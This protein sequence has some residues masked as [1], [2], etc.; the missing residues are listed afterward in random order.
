MALRHRRDLDHEMEAIAALPGVRRELMV[1]GKLSVHEEF[2]DEV[3]AFVIP[4]LS[5]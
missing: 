5:N 1:H 4:F 3:A 2:S